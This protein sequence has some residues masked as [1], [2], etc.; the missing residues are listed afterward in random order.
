MHIHSLPLPTYLLVDAH[1]VLSSSSRLFIYYSN[2]TGECGSCWTFG[3]A[4]SVESYY[5]LSTGQL[6][7]LSEQQILD[8]TPNTN[9]CG[10]TGGCGGGTPELAYAKIIQMG[11]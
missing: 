9:D 6:T 8:C 3:T 7:D 2:L 5:A 1:I 10:G 11:I 4:E